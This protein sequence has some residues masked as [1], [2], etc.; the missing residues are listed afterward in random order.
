MEL[1][2]CVVKNLAKGAQ[3]K[4]TADQLISFLKKNQVTLDNELK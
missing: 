1:K 4:I 2:S 3:E